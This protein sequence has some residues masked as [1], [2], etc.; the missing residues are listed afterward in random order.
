MKREES[1]VDRRRGVLVYV[2]VMCSLSAVALIWA[3]Q[4]ILVVYLGVDRRVVSLF[5]V[6]CSGG[7]LSLLFLVLRLAHVSMG[8]QDRK[9][10]LFEG[11]AALWLL[12]VAIVAGWI[13]V[14]WSLWA[15]FQTGLIR[16][17]VG[18]SGVA[19]LILAHVM[20]DRRFLS[21]IV[22]SRLK[23]LQAP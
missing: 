11:A 18:T 4:R 23:T 5:V 19:L 22:K 15:E 20:I 7:V 13:M 14:G 16:G 1:E 8:M 3:F 9:A 21:R 12:P 2:G 6:C 17:G 10:I